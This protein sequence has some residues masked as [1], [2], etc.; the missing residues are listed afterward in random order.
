MSTF[1]MLVALMT[2]VAL[3]FVIPPMLRNRE[4]QVVDRNQLNT[5]VIKDQ[6]AELRTDLETGKLDQDAYDAASRD[7][8][9]ELLDDL[10]QNAAGGVDTRSG[11]WA[12][13]LLLV[14]VPALAL[15]LYQM[16]GTPQLIERLAAG[17]S[18]T[19]RAETGHE[20]QM[21][22]DKMVEKLAE[23]MRTDPDNAEGWVM[24][25]RSY[26][27]MDRYQD[28]AVAYGKAYQL[29]GDNPRLMTDYADILATAN[30]GV[31]TDQA[32]ELLQKS[33][34]I[35][36][37]DVKTLWLAGHFD[38]QRGN[39][40]RAVNHWQRAAALLPQD[41][42]N[43]T[44]LAQQIRMAKNKLDAS[45]GV[46]PAAPVVSE[47]PSST[48][49]G[50]SQITV[51]VALD[52]GLTA[53]ASD[54]DTVFIFARAVQ[55]PKMPLA[56]VRKQVK[57]LPLTVTLNDSMAMTPAMVLSNFSE[58]TVGARVSKSGQAMPSSGDLQG[59]K[60]PVATGDQSTVEVIIDQAIP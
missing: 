60:S 36:P 42:E 54:E 43:A 12:A 35:N 51:E 15:P 53:Q 17:P 24:L 7:L 59:M 56:I 22:M 38:F 40:S 45:G 13:V 33:L 52:P 41:D 4:Q 10:D 21:S 26:A 50:G 49:S 46:M 39:Y 58:V 55:G 27:A 28:A 14:L 37:E 30:Q 20:G 32:G 11:R 23:R 8:K 47:A 25:G 57:D 9:R 3:L 2:V 1:W 48:A 19:Q 31:F 34:A 5:E 29:V 18:G 44:V 6:L 16:L